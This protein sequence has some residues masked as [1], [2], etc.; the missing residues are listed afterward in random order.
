MSHQFLKNSAFHPDINP[1]ITNLG[2]P[3]VSDL[4]RNGFLFYLKTF[5]TQIFTDKH[6]LVQAAWRRYLILIYEGVCLQSVSPAA[7]KK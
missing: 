4:I 5:W 2:P 1:L 3:I 7:K 6:R